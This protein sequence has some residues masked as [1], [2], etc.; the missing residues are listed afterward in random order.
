VDLTG[1]TKLLTYS[2]GYLELEMYGEAW[3][4]LDE[5]PQ[6]QQMS[7]TV[8]SQR[9]SILMEAKKWNEAVT[10]GESMSQKYKQDESFFIHTAYALHE[11]KK[12]QEAKAILLT[13]PKSI[14]V[15][16]LYHY[17]LGCYEAQLGNSEKALEHT[18]KAI[19][20]DKKF[21][22]IAQTD[23]DLKSVWPLLKSEK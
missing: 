9:L 5:L 19:A 12:T 4:V 6:A 2:Q 3:D 7:K 15:N 1:I 16:P 22:K 17:N 10:L 21:L 23:V 8:L 13:A 14:Q 11:L 20:L 18:K